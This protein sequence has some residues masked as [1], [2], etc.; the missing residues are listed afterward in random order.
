M[1]HSYSTPADRAAGP[2][3]NPG[4]AKRAFYDESAVKHSAPAVT[5]KS[6]ASASRSET[7]R[8]QLH[9]LPCTSTLNLLGQSEADLQVDSSPAATYETTWMGEDSPGSMPYDDYEEVQPQGG[10]MVLVVGG[11]GEKDSFRGSDDS[12][13]A[14][15]ARKDSVICDLLAQCDNLQKESSTLREQVSQLSEFEKSRSLAS[16]CPSSPRSA[17]QELRSELAAAS[18]ALMHERIRRD[19]ETKLLRAELADART[20]LE[21]SESSSLAPEERRSECTKS[22]WP[23]HSASASSSGATAPKAAA[24]LQLMPSSSNSKRTA[25]SNQQVK[26][27]MSADAGPRASI[28]GSGRGRPP[29][30]TAGPLRDGAVI[31]SPS[32]P[33]TLKLKS[34]STPVSEAGSIE[35]S[36]GGSLAEYLP[37]ADT[38]KE[39]ASANPVAVAVAAAAASLAPARARCNSDS[40]NASRRSSPSAKSRA[41]ASARTSPTRSGRVAADGAA[42]VR[43]SG[44][45]SA[46]ALSAQGRLV[47]AQSRLSSA[48]QSR[49]PSESPSRRSVPSAVTSARDSFA[50]KSSAPALRTSVSP[51]KR[52]S[53]ARTPSP[54]SPQMSASIPECDSSKQTVGQASFSV[55]VAVVAPRSTETTFTQRAPV[56]LPTTTVAAT[57]VCSTPGRPYFTP[58]PSA[59]TAVGSMQVA[60]CMRACPTVATTR[61]ASTA[62]LRPSQVWTPQNPNEPPQRSSMDEYYHLYNVVATPLMQSPDNLGKAFWAFNRANESHKMATGRES[63]EA[64]YNL[65]CCLSRAAEEQLKRSKPNFVDS[66]EALAEL[67]RTPLNAT[68]AVAPDLPPNTSPTLSLHDFVH[69]RLNLAADFLS[70]AASIGSTTCPKSAHIEADTDLRLLRDL[71]ADVFRG[72]VHHV[73][74]RDSMGHAT[75]RSSAPPGAP[76][77]AH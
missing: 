77:G 52:S 63:G 13:A 46:R 33:S 14:I 73:A 23:H 16:T 71:R 74:S 56:C 6:S 31:H 18:S 15:L 37:Q 58:M 39:E 72:V 41:A 67:A 8:S 62:H 70:R 61:I 57:S 1:L 32:P 47:T 36:A 65:A 66:R 69:S 35:V 55:P 27:S 50:M 51:P 24:K 21:K 54:A 30:R 44:S 26:H 7:P 20:Q 10:S 4:A 40:L 29:W 5:P 42:V 17:S 9:E 45:T 76:V 59:K 34:R 2:P 48:P 25:S 64:I 43:A 60:P 53:R 11:L 19:A 28:A 12:V 3:L 68:S 75:R 49:I 22:G 38:K